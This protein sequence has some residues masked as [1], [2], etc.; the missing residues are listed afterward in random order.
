VP[1]YDYKC[2]LT[3]QISFIHLATHLNTLVDIC[4]DKSEDLPTHACSGDDSDTPEGFLGAVREFFKTQT[5]DFPWQEGDSLIV[6]NLL[7]THGRVPY[8]GPRKVL[9][10]MS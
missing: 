2:G 4:E 10:A 5:I 3:K 8:S 6:D 7:M 9:V 1:T